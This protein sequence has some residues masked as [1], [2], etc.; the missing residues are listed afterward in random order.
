MQHITDLHNK[1]EGKLDR[2]M[3][4]RLHRFSYGFGW[5][6]ETEEQKQKELEDLERFERD[7][8]LPPEPINVRTSMFAGRPNRDE[9]SKFDG[10]EDEKKDDGAKVEEM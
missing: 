6:K 9:V 8:A 1:T 5:N 4:G 7:G 2:G 3:R 10:A